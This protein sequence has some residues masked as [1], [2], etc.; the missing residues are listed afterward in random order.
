VPV[1]SNGIGH[2]F[3]VDPLVDYVPKDVSRLSVPRG[4]YKI[5]RLLPERDGELQYRVRSAA[6]GHE[7]VALESELGAI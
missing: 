6:E 5:T 7:R 2:K 4:A 1:A 3:N